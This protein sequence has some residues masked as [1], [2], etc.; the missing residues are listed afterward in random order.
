[1]IRN[2]QLLVLVGV[3]LSAVIC[4]FSIQHNANQDRIRDQAT[5]GQ[6]CEDRQDA[7]QAVRGLVFVATSQTPIDFSQFPSYELLDPA[8]KQFLS[9][10][11]EASQRGELSDFRE[12]ALA[13]LP[14]ITCG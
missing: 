8:M 14:T 7:R 12:R 11:Q 3:V 13:D 4:I 5:Q 9:E 10:F 6:A 2:K 1:M